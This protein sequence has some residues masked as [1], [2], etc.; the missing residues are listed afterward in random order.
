MD[1]Y[2]EAQLRALDVVSDVARSDDVNMLGACAGGLTTGLM[3]DHLSH[4][5]EQRANAATVMI[6]MLETSYPNILAMPLLEVGQAVERLL[7]GV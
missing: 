4:R 2:L 6:S 5:G 7:V 1:D 3:L